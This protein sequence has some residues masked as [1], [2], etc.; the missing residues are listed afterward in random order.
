M[1][2]DIAS[3]AAGAFLLAAPAAAVI[4]PCLP[5]YAD[6]WQE[7]LEADRLRIVSAAR[8]AAPV[9]CPGPPFSTLKLELL[10][11]LVRAALDVPVDGVHRLAV[12]KVSVD[13]PDMDPGRGS[14]ELL[15]E[16]PFLRF[17]GGSGAWGLSIELNRLN[18]SHLFLQLR[19]G[20]SRQ[21]EL[22]AGSKDPPA[23]TL[24]L[25]VARK[26]CATRVLIEPPEGTGRRRVVPVLE[27]SACKAAGVAPGEEVR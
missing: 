17:E 23:H 9:I 5:H 14:D 25:E 22:A 10:Q 21:V 2:T 8:E 24:A 4:P 7:G 27:A 11:A 20:L 12:S 6:C 15:A 19:Q 18:A 1:K 16:Y 26:A 3:L 13:F